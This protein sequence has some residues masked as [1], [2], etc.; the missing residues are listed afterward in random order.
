MISKIG[1]LLTSKENGEQIGVI[2]FDPSGM[3][4]CRMIK[5]GLNEY[6]L[7]TVIN[8]SDEKGFPP[9]YKKYK[10]RMD[11]KGNLPKDVLSS[12][13]DAYAEIVNEANVKIGGIP[14]N[15]S[16]RE[17]QEPTNLESK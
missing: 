7:R 3:L 8:L 10:T 9:L 1:V 11:E 5:R 4:I 16:V 17:W 12:E 14:V 15:A 6:A 2:E 13:A